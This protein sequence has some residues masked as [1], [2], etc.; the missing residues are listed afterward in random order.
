MDVKSFLFSISVLAFLANNVKAEVPNIPPM[1]SKD[2]W[3][4]TCLLCLANP[5]GWKS[6]S[7]CV[8][9]VKKLLKEL[10]KGKSMPK[11]PSAGVGNDMV[12]THQRYNPCNAK[13]REEKL[14]EVSGWVAEPGKPSRFAHPKGEKRIRVERGDHYTWKTVYPGL[15]CAKTPAIDFRS[16]SYY[17][18]SERKY[19]RVAVYEKIIWE[20]VQERTNIDIYVDGELWQRVP[21][22]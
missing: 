20:N 16:E 18:G 15:A 10:R 19:R 3:A 4:C 2:E 1:S 6:V 22:I 13:S 21:G 5:N 12:L 8:P 9:P 17:D 11:C 14:V 7:E